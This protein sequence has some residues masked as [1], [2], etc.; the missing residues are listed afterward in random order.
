MPVVSIGDH[1]LA[2]MS[3]PA[4]SP[5]R[6]R[7]GEETQVVGESFHVTHHRTLPTVGVRPLKPTQV[8]L[9]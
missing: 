8:L 9:K 5:R 3:F 7:R 4:H 2:I 6:D 1:R